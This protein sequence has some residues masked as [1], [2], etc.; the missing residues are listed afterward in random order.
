[1]EQGRTSVPSV[2]PKPIIVS[3]G[4]VVPAPSPIQIDT[5]LSL[6]APRLLPY[7]DFSDTIIHRN[8]Y[9]DSSE[10]TNSIFS[11]IIH[12]YN[13]NAFDSFLVKHNLLHFY[14][15][16][17]RNLKEGFPLGD[18]PALTS[19]III[20]NHPSVHQHPDLIDKYIRDEV[21]TGRMSGP[22]SSGYI[23]HVMRGEFFSSPFL[24]SVQVQQPGT[25]DK[26]RVC[27]HLSKDD[28]NHPSVNSHIKKE[29]FPTRFDT[30][31]R[32]ADIVSFVLLFSNCFCSLCFQVAIMAYP[33]SS[34]TSFT[35]GGSAYGFHLRWWPTTYELHLWWLFLW[36]SPLVA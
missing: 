23:K 11:R 24:V 4:F 36:A 12:P 26:L 14:P 20:P 17:V 2:A 21:D 30:A 27:R 32:V 3:P 33:F 18:M 8:S 31:S 19:T 28:K 15:F 7:R 34:M 9:E 13:S 22:F 6:T 35:S 29:D 10:Q 25:P 1:M 16:L 5:F